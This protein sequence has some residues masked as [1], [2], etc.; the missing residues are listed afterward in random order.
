M[1]RI[2]GVDTEAA[3]QIDDGQDCMDKS[4]KKSMMADMGSSDAITTIPTQAH[5]ALLVHRK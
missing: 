4:Q 3:N 5:F 1:V 2:L